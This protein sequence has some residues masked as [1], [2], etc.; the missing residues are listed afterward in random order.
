MTLVRVEADWT[1]AAYFNEYETLRIGVLPSD[2]L[3]LTENELVSEA[4][5]DEHWLVQK[6]YVF[7]NVSS[8]ELAYEFVQRIKEELFDNG[9]FQ[10]R[11]NVLA[12]AV[13]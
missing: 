12:V 9:F 2:A 13:S 3:A 11:I 10:A 7:N 8:A 1:I 6:P 5:Q 4:E